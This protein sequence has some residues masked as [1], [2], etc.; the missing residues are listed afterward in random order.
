MP[1]TALASQVV[2]DE[3][4]TPVYSA[5]N[6]DGHSLEG[7]GD[8]ILHVKTGASGCTVTIQTGGTLMGEAVAEKAVVIAANSERFIGRFPAALYNQPSGA[9]AGKVYVD[10]S[11]VA[12]VTVAAI[13]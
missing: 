8:V 1:R 2:A 13:R 3:G 10:F 5:A 9:D 12:T 7:G 11:A 4:I 6:I